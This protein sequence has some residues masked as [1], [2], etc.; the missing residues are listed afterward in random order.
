MLGLPTGVRLSGP[1]KRLLA[2]LL[3]GLLFLVTL[4]IGWI[5]WALIAWARGTTPAKQLMRMTVIWTANRRAASWGRMFLR[6]A[7]GRGLV[8]P[9]ISFLTFGVGWIVATCMVF[10]DTRQTLWDR[11]ASTLVVD[12]YA[13]IPPE[14]LPAEQGFDGASYTRKDRKLALAGAG[15]LVVL[16]LAGI[17]IVPGLF[18]GKPTAP[19]GVGADPGITSDYP[20]RTSFPSDTTTSEEFMTTT[21]S[22]SPSEVVSLAP[23]AQT[24]PTAQAAATV[25]GT[26]FTS[27]NQGDTDAAWALHTANQKARIGDKA[28]WVRGIEQTYDTDVVIYDMQEASDHT[29]QAWVTFTSYQPSQYGPSGDTCNR[30]DLLYTLVPNGTAYLI[31]KA[32]PRNGSGHTTC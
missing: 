2:Y 11:L 24:H 8:V 19:L 30:W 21:L 22:A 23:A 27:I 15:A 28:T 5:V 1:G 3:E 16:L 9:V 26:Y 14:N 17:V 31:D 4:G 18:A 10:S 32:T 12:G 13:D 29:V 25:F 20:T 7:A 6:E